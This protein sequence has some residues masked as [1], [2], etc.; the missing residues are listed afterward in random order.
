LRSQAADLV[1]LHGLGRTPADWDGVRDD[2]SPFGRVVSPQLPSAPAPA[3]QLLDH[4]I[5]PEAI[6]VAHSM[7]AVLLMRL[8]KSRPRPLRAV[9][10]TG[11]FFPPARNGR[12]LGASV[13]DY[14][15][16]RVAF[17]R[18]SRGQRTQRADRGAVRPLAS[19]LR[20]ALLPGGLEEALA[21]VTPSVL[22][23]HARDDHHVPVDYAIA[24][25]RRRSNW[26]LEILD[27][28]GHHAHV[29][30]PAAWSALVTRWL[31]HVVAD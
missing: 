2:L 28:G 13:A 7:G 4:T 12:T 22:I 26:T 20:L 3:L 19:L 23:V 8:A 14:A 30:R 16:H 29:T 25:Q 9:I 15:A 10:L 18:A 5:S 1:C 24:A 11:C 27:H 6:V 21:R 17:V 31:A